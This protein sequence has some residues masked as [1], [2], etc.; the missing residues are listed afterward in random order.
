MHPLSHPEL[1]RAVTAA[2]HDHGAGR[3]IRGLTA[4]RTLRRRRLVLWVISA[5]RP[6]ARRAA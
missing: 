5:A 6:S 2:R 3:P 4:T 1:L